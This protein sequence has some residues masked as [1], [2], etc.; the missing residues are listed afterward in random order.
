MKALHPYIA[1]A[2]TCAEAMTFYRDCLG[3]E[4]TMQKVSEAPIAGQM[5]PQMQDK[6]MHSTLTIGDLSLMASDMR[7]PWLDGDGSNI[8]VM[9]HCSSE[10]ELHRHFTALAKGGEVR[11]PAGEK[12]WGGHFGALTDKFGVNWSLHFDKAQAS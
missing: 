5:P 11:D 7:P 10:E 9:L 8:S 3:G 6:I 1:F 2:G 4:L 12:F